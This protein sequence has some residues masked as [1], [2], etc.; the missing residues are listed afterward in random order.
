MDSLR[1]PVA[2]LIAPAPAGGAE[3]VVRV[4]AGSRQRAG[5]PTRVVA[6]LD[7]PEPHPFVEALRG[8]GIPVDVV[9]SGRRR[10]WEEARRVTGIL[11][12]TGTGI[13]H[14]HGYQ[15]NV[16][17]SLGAGRAG[18]A[19]VVTHHGHIGGGGWKGDL[20]Q[21][22]DLRTMKKAA[23]VMAVSGPT[24]KALLDAGIPPERLHVVRNGLAGV[25]PLSRGEARERLGLP[26]EAR[27]VGWV[28]RLSREKGGDLLLEAL[29]GWGAVDGG[30]LPGDPGSHAPMVIMVGD[31]PEREALE[32]RARE[33][34]GEGVAVRLVGSRDDAPLLSR[35][36]D[37]LA[38]SSRI[39]N[40]P[41]VLLEAAAAAT[42]VV[43]FG[44]GGIP[45]VL[46]ATGGW[47][48]APGDTGALGRALG[49]ALADPGEA[50]R[51]AE[52]VRLRV[53]REFGSTAWRDE[54]ER[55]YTL[56][57]QSR[58]RG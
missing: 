24:R 16:V 40:L 57:V 45:E 14:T 31:G 25:E 10:Y 48:V 15:A 37:V 21:W 27:V 11:R 1:T 56:A 41:M 35:A 2:H 23:A 47:V 46:D 38:I 18:A 33:L 58:H 9:P 53:E 30:A 12:G 26:M 13:L 5:R 29:A 22:L 44:V 4:L 39:E 32:A 49:E 55:I 50:R 6:L 28:G 36:F 52:A 51:R 17:G 3:T 43:A 54:T 7:A 20:Y 19:H 42:P 34:A 8:D